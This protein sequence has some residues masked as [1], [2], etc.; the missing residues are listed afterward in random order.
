MMWRI[1][2]LVGR[3]LSRCH[4]NASLRLSQGH[5]HTHVEDELINSSVLT[6]G[7][8]A[9]DCSSSQRDGDDQK[10]RRSEFC[11]SGLPRYTALDA[12]GWGAAAVLF[13]QLCRRI[14]SRFSSRA[15]Q[16]RITDVGLVQKCS[17]KV[18]IDILSQESVLSGGVTV[19]C[20]QGAL[21]SPEPSGDISSDTSS[22]EDLTSDLQTPETAGPSHS[23]ETLF[24]EPVKPQERL[25]PDEAAQK[26]RH[27]A[28]S[29]VPIILNIIGLESAKAGDYEAAFSC[30][31]ASA[32][33]DYSKA[34]FNVGVCYERGRG[35]RRDH[36]KAVL[37]YRRAAVAGHRQAQYRCAKLLLN[38]RGQQSSESDSEAA[39]NFLYAAADAGLT[40]AQMYLGVVLSQGSDL[41]K[42]QSVHYFRMAAEQGDSGALVC[43]AQCYEKGLGVSPCVHTAV[44]LYQ[45]AEARGNLQARDVLTD[46]HSREVL[47]SIRSAPCFSVI[48]QLNL[49]AIVP[50]KPRPQHESDCQSK[51]LCHSW[52]T[53]SLSSLSSITLQMLSADSKVW[54]PR[55]R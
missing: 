3:V 41:D 48:G 50:Q 10:R 16:N 4:G 23:E 2:S 42:K 6:S 49:N 53:G 37:Y 27:V 30:F 29:S 36:S 43:L 32:Q 15:D 46:R 51:S 12:M 35:V 22:D 26:L 7:R 40:E 13:M 55:V 31:L 47:R 14:H 18:L 25:A 24:P 39:L 8:H 28:D 9:S 52:S 5:S 11:Y 21:Q 54:T 20:L 19:K 17:Y 33:H 44:K 1:Q 38:S 34:Q 45:Q